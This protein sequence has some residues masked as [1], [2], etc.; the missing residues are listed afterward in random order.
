MQ[1]YESHRKSKGNTYGTHR[2]LYVA[3]GNQ[4]EVHAEFRIILW[5]SQGNPY[6]NHWEPIGNPQGIVWKSIGNP[7][8]IHGESIGNQ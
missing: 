5:E 3:T 7:Y 6:E 1:P 8:E 2:N 4:Y